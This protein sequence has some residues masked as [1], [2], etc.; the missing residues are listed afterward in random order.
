MFKFV[1]YFLFSCN[2]LAQTTTITE[3]TTSVLSP[4]ESELD[5]NLSSGFY[6]TYKD[7]LGV[8]H[9]ES[10]IQLTYLHNLRT[11]FQVGGSVG[12]YNIDKKSYLTIYATGVVNL[13]P[14]YTN[15]FYASG[16]VGAKTTDQ[17]DEI[18][19]QIKQKA[20]FYG[21]IG[22]GK[23]IAIRKHISYKPYVA[24]SKSGNFTPEYSIHFLNFSLNW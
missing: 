4:F 14:D 17:A 21:S 23:R 24:V 20:S 5:I 10:N 8:E 19:F 1:I 12:L 16:S 11:P 9:T 22:I 13:L 6:R 15:S 2:S 3:T 7:I 18:T